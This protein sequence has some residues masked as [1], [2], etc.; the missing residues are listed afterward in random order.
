[1]MLIFNGVSEGVFAFFIVFC[2]VAGMVTG[3]YLMDKN[4]FIL[5][6]KEKYELIKEKALHIYSST[7][8]YIVGFKKRAKLLLGR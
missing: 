2:A 6:V 5:I 4:R 8:H 1:M 3:A 7:V